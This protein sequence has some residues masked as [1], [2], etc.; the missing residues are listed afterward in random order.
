VQ[1]AAAPGLVCEPL[2]DVA[3]HIFTTR[4]WRLGSTGSRNVEEGWAEVAEA[5]DAKPANLTRLHQVH[6]ATVFVATDRR[7]DILPRADIV[8]SGGN[9]AIA[10]QVADCVPLLIADTRTGAIVA[11][12]AGW[13]GL[14]ARVPQVAVAALT[15][16][17]GSRPGDLI[18]AAGPSIGA[19]CYEVGSEVRDA[20]IRADDDQRV[21]RW[22]VA[23]PQPTAVNPSMA[24]VAKP[25]RPDHWFMDP[26]AIVR[27]QLEE[28]GLLPDRIHIA[29]LCTAS[30]P[31]LFCSYRRDGAPAGRM[32]GVITRRQQTPRAAS[33]K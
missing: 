27:G 33:T 29:E 6:G 22:F 5:V 23:E 25:A 16:Q 10:V 28:A 32:A 31:A 20:F 11:A 13:R 4:P 12:H 3:P 9:G 24:G 18:A 17:F 15:R 2:A 8:L 7:P 26:W 1:A 19:C 14:A 30:H 21:E